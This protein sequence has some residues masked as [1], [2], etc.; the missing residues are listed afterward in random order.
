M[1]RAYLPLSGSEERDDFLYNILQIF[2]D[3]ENIVNSRCFLQA[4]MFKNFIFLLFNINGRGGSAHYFQKP[5]NQK[6]SSMQN[7]KW[8]N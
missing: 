7:K 1:Y 8:Q 3:N 5:L 6:K 4:K 2:L